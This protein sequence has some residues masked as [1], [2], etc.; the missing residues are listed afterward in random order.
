MSSPEPKPDLGPHPFLCTLDPHGPRHNAQWPQVGMGYSRS[1][2]S[3]EYLLSFLQDN[4]MN[5]EKKKK[6]SHCVLKFLEG[7]RQNSETPWA[8]HSLAPA[9][10]ILVLVGGVF[11]QKR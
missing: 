3:H 9:L 10:C 11:A 5:F 6:V 8:E 7:G 2:P 4:L 1:S